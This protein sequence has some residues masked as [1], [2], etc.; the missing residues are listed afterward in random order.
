V[1]EFFPLV[2]NDGRLWERES[3]S[4]RVPEGLLV[5]SEGDKDSVF[6]DRMANLV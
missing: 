4:R 6:D 1:P 5:T 3:L 2:K